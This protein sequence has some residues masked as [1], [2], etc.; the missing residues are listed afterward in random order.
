MIGQTDLIIFDCD[1]VLLDT[2]AIYTQVDVKRLAQ[3]GVKM[4]AADV[5]ARFAGKAHSDAWAELSREFGFALPENWIDDILAECMALF[6][7]GL[8]PTIGTV[9]MMDLLVKQDIRF[10]SASTTA[11]DRLKRNME[12]G[13]LSSYFGDNIFSASQVAR[14]K[15]APDVYMFAAEQMGVAPEACLALEDS[16]TGAA[17]AVAAGIP[18]LGFTGGGHSYPEH[19]KALL[20]AGC[21]D[22]ICN[23]LELE[24]FV[25]AA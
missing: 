6:E 23:M 17:A 14:P 19:G 4:V 15:P 1:G 10:C 22:V 18:V 12:V 20:D 11:Y 2:E 9:D 25:L 24:K 5:A 8:K 21:F 3:F 13:G 7:K 16:A